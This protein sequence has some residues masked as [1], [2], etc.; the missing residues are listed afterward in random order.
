[1]NRCALSLIVVGVAMLLARG[2]ASAADDEALIKHGLELR[3]KG[4]D[5]A[6]LAEFRRAHELSKSGRALAQVSLA[7]QA[8]GHWADAEAHLIEAMRH[9][10]EP[11][12]ARNMRLFKQ[13]LADIQSHLGSLQL[14][15][16]TAGAEVA[17]NGAPSGTLPLAAPLRVPAGSVALE[18]RAPDHL[19][20][21][22]TVIIPAGGLARE[23]VVLV[24]IRS[25]G[26]VTPQVAANERPP[27]HVDTPP[28]RDVGP[29]GGE[30][31]APASGGGWSA[32]RKL[33]AGMAAAGVASLA[34]GIAFHLIRNSRASDFNGAGCTYGNGNVGGPTGCSS[35][36]E[37]VQQA[38]NFAI[39]GYGGAVLLGGVGAFL[40]FTS[41]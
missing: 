7:E 38:R 35:R 39:G 10:Q 14:S 11:W 17:I 2:A 31:V 23:Q 13:A 29:A 15:G 19:P 5:E 20:M 37:D 6:A 22:R 4:D 26:Q 3:E 21:L 18:V 34:A 28:P 12:V 9:D 16:G 1:M 24:P 8:L 32:R 40:F 25:A 36:Y 41:D 33:G 30:I 27:V